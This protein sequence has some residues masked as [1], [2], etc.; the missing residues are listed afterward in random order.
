MIFS[1]THFTYNIAK[2]KNMVSQLNRTKQTRTHQMFSNFPKHLFPLVS[3]HFN[4][5]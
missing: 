5:V 4:Y 1:L 3:K 2:K